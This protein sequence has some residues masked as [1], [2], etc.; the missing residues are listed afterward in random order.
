MYWGVHG[1]I[2]KTDS[3]K[4]E[5][6]NI[7]VFCPALTD[8]S[9]GDMLFCHSVHSPGLVV[10]IVQG[11]FDLISMLSTFFYFFLLLFSLSI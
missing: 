7:P 8:G 5:Q 9:I 6:N 4:L 10:D 1:N 2:S 11:W 3:S